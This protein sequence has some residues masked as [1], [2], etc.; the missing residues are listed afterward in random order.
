VEL[1]SFTAVAGGEGV[2]LAWETA[3]ELDLLGFHLYRAGSPGGA[4][5]RLNAE[6]IPA[7]HPGSPVGATY[8]YVDAFVKPGATYWYWLDAVDVLGQASRHGPV[9]VQVAGAVYRVY[10]PL[11]GK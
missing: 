1:L 11:I 4:Q 2:R 8:E 6:L 10:L 5:T 9:S 3:T 7:Q